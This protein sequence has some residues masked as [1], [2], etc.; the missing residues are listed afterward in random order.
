[1]EIVHCSPYFYFFRVSSILIDTSS[2]E[3]GHYRYVEARGA[4]RLEAPCHR[5]ENHSNFC[6]HFVVPQNTFSHFSAL[7]DYC[8]H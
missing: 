7:V 1:M 6:L 2:I 4:G 8:C 5:R 3:N